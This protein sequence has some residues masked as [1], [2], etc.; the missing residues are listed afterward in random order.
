MTLASAKPRLDAFPTALSRA[1][2]AMGS[3]E[4]VTDAQIFGALEVAHE[5]FPI[6]LEMISGLYAQSPRTGQ[7]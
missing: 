1:V 5:V 2:W 4:K 3:P 6:E 7:E